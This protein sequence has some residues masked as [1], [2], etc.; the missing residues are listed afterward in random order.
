MITCHD[1]LGQYYA[2][3]ILRSP[4]L[5]HFLESEWN[6]V[7]PIAL[8]NRN[9]DEVNAHD[10]EGVRS[11]RD[12]YLKKELKEVSERDEAIARAFGDAF[13]VGGEIMSKGCLNFPA[14]LET[15]I[16]RAGVLCQDDT[17]DHCPGNLQ[18][19]I[20]LRRSRQLQV[21][22]IPLLEP[23]ETNAQRCTGK[24]GNERKFINSKSISLLGLV[25][26][27]KT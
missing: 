9:S 8:F 20:R 23:F 27:L 7:A 10:L 22:I 3:T 12:F 26:H 4:Q 15:F 24:T 1:V 17:G 18:L 5:S 25:R 21:R 19:Q 2:A 13:C 6:E 14:S 11:V 16:Y